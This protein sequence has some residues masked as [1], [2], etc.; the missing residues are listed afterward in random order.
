[1]NG[2]LQ[3]SPAGPPFAFVGAGCLVG[4]L[5][6]TLGTAAGAEAKSKVGIGAAVAVATGVHADEEFTVAVDTVAPRSVA[7]RLWDNEGGLGLC[8]S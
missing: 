6:G 1:M 2:G 4:R 8:R 3:S 5:G 7:E